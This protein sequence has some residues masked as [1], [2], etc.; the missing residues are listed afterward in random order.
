MI[1]RGEFER[2]YLAGCSDSARYDFQ[3]VCLE[4]QRVE[5]ERCISVVRE[6]EKLTAEGNNDFQYSRV[7]AILARVRHGIESPK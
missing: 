4:I 3:K 1:E 7:M 2:V 5:R 6:L